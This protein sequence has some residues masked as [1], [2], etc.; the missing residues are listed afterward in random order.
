[1]KKK[2]L[3]IAII[4]NCSFIM[5]QTE[6]DALKVVQ[7]DINGTARYMS[8]AG[9]FGALGG[10]A[11]AIKDNPAGFGIYRSSEMT[12]TLNL[13]VQNSN[14]IWNATNGYDNLNKI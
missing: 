9:A 10:D 2:I 4:L 7:S 12:G 14:S 6:F 3:T 8:M 11:S 5:A 1:M 13:M